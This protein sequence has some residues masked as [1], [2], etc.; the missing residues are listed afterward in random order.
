M[1]PNLKIIALSGSAVLFLFLFMRWIDLA[2]PVQKIGSLLP[3]PPGNNGAAI[4]V[5][6]DTNWDELTRDEL[7]CLVTHFGNSKS[8]HS[9]EWNAE[10]TLGQTVITD[11]Y[12]GNSGEFVMSRL[13]P[14]LNK[15]GVSNSP[16]MVRVCT[17]CIDVSGNLRTLTDYNLHMFELRPNHLESGIV[18]GADEGSYNLTI[19]AERSPDQSRF[20]F[21]ALGGFEPR[22]IKGNDDEKD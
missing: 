17:Q 8:R 21:K 22:K 10:V 7:Q 19:K 3:T 11:A 1:K 6:S 20:D 12:E 9:F 18:I 2:E 15:D 14:T 5:P 16:I 4:V 13:T